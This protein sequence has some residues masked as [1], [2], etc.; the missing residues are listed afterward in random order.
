MFAL[1]PNSGSVVPSLLHNADELHDSSTS[2]WN[3]PIRNESN[4]CILL[5]Q[6]RWQLR[7]MRIHL[8]LKEIWLC[9]G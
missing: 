6:H 1:L 4:A 8:P 9:F 5:N 7:R 3:R 2:C